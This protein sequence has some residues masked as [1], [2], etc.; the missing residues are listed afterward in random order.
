MPRLLES[1]EL[2]GAQ[3]VRGYDLQKIFTLFVHPVTSTKHFQEAS[4]R[5]ES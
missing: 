2:S 5:A 1:N 4:D 3:E